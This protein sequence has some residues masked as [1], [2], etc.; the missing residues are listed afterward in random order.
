MELNW[1]PRIPWSDD[2]PGAAPPQPPWP[3]DPPGGL[4]PLPPP[5]RTA[6]PGPGEATEDIAVGPIEEPEGPQA[7]KQD[8]KAKEPARSWLRQVSF[9]S[10]ISI[11][12]GAA[13]GIAVAM[14][15]LVSYVAVGRQLER[16]ATTNLDNAIGS[17]SGLV[18][19]QGTTGF[20]TQRVFNFQ[21]QTGDSVQVITKTEVVSLQSG[22]PSNS[23]FFPMSTGAA[24]VLKNGPGGNAIIETVTATNGEP[25]RVASVPTA[26]SGVVVQIGYP[27]TA[28]DNTL[29]FL[30]LMLVLV[31]LG[32]VAVATGLGWAVGRTSMRP[33]ED[34]TLAAEHVAATQDLSATID[35]DGN[36]E[37]ARLAAQL[38]RHACGP[39]I[40]E[41]PAD[42]ARFRRRARTTHT[43]HKSAHQHRGSY[44]DQRPAVG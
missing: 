12:V 35:D 4:A 8:D 10:R 42:T 2:G 44:A 36:D 33:V 25:Y 32:G 22:Q 21:N 37:L 40:V 19:F 20:V 17:A 30:R 24:Q 11:L 7:A 29:A 43:P 34:L 26:I 23:R 5:G 38:Q 13:V 3:I 16:Q 6:P 31:A 9:R 28:V 1:A 14:A 15:A 18:A 41:A 27:L 39:G